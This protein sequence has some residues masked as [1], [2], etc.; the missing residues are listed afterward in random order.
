[1]RSSTLLS[2]LLLG[3]LALSGLAA[4]S[5]FFS[6]S[7]SA[8][9]QQLI[10][11]AQSKDGSF[12]GKIKDTHDAVAALQQLK[13]TIPN[14]ASVC[15]YAKTALN[16][17]LESIYHAVAVLE[18]LS[19]G[20]KVS[21]DV[22]KKISAGLSGDNVVDF[23]R[24]VATWEALQANGH[25][26]VDSKKALAG[27]SNL[28]NLLN[29][30]EGLFK[31]NA[32]SDEG[33]A[34]WTGLALKTLASLFKH[35][36]D[37]ERTKIDGV[38]SR[39]GATMKS[40]DQVEGTGLVFKH[41]DGSVSPLR[42]TA[43]LI[44]GVSSYT[45]VVRKDKGVKEV[46]DAHVSNIAEYLVQHKSVGTVSEGQA[47]VLGL[48]AVASVR[49][50]PLAVS[51]VEGTS[52]LSDKNGEVKLRVTDV[53]GHPV[54]KAAVQ[55]N[56]ASTP[57]KKEAVAT[58]VKLT[59]S[60]DG[61][62]AY[63]LLASKPDAGAYTLDLSVT[64]P[65]KD[66]QSTTSTKRVV[67]VATKIALQSVEAYL[68]DSSEADDKSA[69][70]R[71]IT[72]DPTGK[73]AAPS[74]SVAA[75][76][77]NLHFVA[78]LRADA[79][80]TQVKQAHLKLI[81]ADENADAVTFVGKYDAK[82]KSY[83]WSVN[84]DKTAQLFVKGQYKLELVLGDPFAENAIVLHAANVNVE[85]GSAKPKSASTSTLLPEIQH[86]FAVPE[87]RPPTTLSTLFTGLTLAPLAFLLI[88]F[89]TVGANIRDF[90][91]GVA[92]LPAVGFQ[93]TF[94]LMLAL[95]FQ[96]WLALNMFQALYYAGALAMPLIYFGNRTLR[97]VNE[98][99]EKKN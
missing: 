83:K 45:N 80:L 72:V 5:D 90:P 34:Y 36:D 48:N 70:S 88:G 11:K 81:P 68:T 95:L 94:G 67:R 51:V 85:V 92:F 77:T 91:T 19:C 78:A 96:Y 76:Q 59:E 28:L 84:F 47:L 30:K 62:F 58:N 87:K 32:D 57:A 16:G 56:K 64:S 39:I 29:E 89:L 6:S 74:V 98:V 22:T 42:T 40:G 41:V 10:N 65:S 15:S 86:V 3:V 18:A 97:Y 93:V 52:T 54:S 9:L 17:D 99:R 79:G 69:N 21:D 46:T 63:N 25:T 55:I 82:A 60:N 44:D 4:V 43:T 73:T 13:A 26:T 31:L 38:A 27:L 33:S 50:Q 14:Q 49:P 2:I 75:G 66:F 24:A 37:S 61:V 8:A 7:D 20:E 12:N 1:M 53:F 71:R 35:A 23:Y